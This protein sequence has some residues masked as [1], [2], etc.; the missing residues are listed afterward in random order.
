LVDMDPC[1]TLAE[2]V[3]RIVQLFIDDAYWL[4]DRTGNNLIR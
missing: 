1:H 4:P 3:D 2:Y